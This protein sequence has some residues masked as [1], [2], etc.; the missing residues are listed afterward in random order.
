MSSICI[1]NNFVKFI[2]K[3]SCFFNDVKYF[4]IFNFI[5]FF[6]F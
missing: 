6:F 1:G 4:F 2:A 5:I 3:I